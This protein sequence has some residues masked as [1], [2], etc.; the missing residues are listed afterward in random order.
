MKIVRVQ[1][2][3]TPEYAPIN[4]ANIAGIVKEL[5]ELNYVGIKY[6]T[7]IL[8]DGKTFMHFDH[9]ENEEDHQLLISLESF[10]KFDTELWA[11]GLEIEPKL[12]L[13]S[14]VVSTD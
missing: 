12:D 10:K 7:W 2:T 1:Y 11:S 14:L 6:G 8:P 9:F 3:T 5:K 4:I 13:L